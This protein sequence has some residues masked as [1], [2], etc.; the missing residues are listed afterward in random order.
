VHNFAELDAAFPALAAGEPEA[1]V[2]FPD[3][4]TVRRR[5]RIID[6][7]ETRHLP[8]ISA[9]AIFAQSEALCTYGP[10]LTE[11]YK[12]AAYHVDRIIKG[13]RPGLLSIEQPTRFELVVNLKTANALGLT[14]PRTILARADEV[15]E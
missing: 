9:W 4:V 8:V 1:L 12:R 15:I 3:P 5:Q 6:F 2:V 10:R 13:E 7:A 14:V 11:S